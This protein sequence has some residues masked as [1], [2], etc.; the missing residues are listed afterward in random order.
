MSTLEG[1]AR[2][3]PGDPKQRGE[4]VGGEKIPWGFHTS[5]WK[6]LLKIPIKTG[7]PGHLGYRKFHDFQLV[8][9]LSILYSC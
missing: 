5:T 2:Y 6:P 7:Y 4:A 1:A 8:F 9:S 3:M